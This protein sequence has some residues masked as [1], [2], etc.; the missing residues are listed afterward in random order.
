M[1]TLDVPE[2]EDVIDNYNKPG[3]PEKNADQDKHLGEKPHLSKTNTDYDITYGD[4]ATVVVSRQIVLKKKWIVNALCH[5]DR[6][7]DHEYELDELQC[8]LQHHHCEPMLL[9]IVVHLTK[10]RVQIINMTPLRLPLLWNHVDHHPLVPI[11]HL[12]SAPST[13]PAL[14]LRRTLIITIRPS[15]VISIWLIG[16]LQDIQV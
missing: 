16:A 9:V 4:L 13:W 14:K 6:E 5:E 15:W 1:K 3:D 10:E 8:L 2:L 7:D 11:G 12:S